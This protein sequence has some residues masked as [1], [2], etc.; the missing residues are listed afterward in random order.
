MRTT[1][2]AL[3]AGLAMRDALEGLNDSLRPRLGVELD[4]RI[5]IATGEALVSGGE[6]ALATGDVMNT[7]ARLEQGAAPGEILLARETMQ[8]S[9]VVIAVGSS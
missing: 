2:S 6:N 5:G 7:A 8:L 3:C 1:P 4:I 9:R